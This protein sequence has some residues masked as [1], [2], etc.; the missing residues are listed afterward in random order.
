MI[1][2]FFQSGDDD[3][4]NLDSTSG[5]DWGNLGKTFTHY[6]KIPTKIFIL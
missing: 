2:H 5:K 4:N 6:Q 3:D 1:I